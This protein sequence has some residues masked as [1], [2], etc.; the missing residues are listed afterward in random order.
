VTLIPFRRIRLN[1]KKAMPATKE[2]E[3]SNV[4]HAQQ[5]RNTLATYAYPTMGRLLVRDVALPH[6]RSYEFV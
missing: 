5:W 3:W 1:D 6:G 4:K 2:S